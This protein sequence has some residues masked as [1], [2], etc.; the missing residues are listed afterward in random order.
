[1]YP[2][3][4]FHVIGVDKDNDQFTIA[5]KTGFDPDCLKRQ[6]GAFV[7][8]FR[9]FNKTSIMLSTMAAPH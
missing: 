4:F 2:I 5:G 3:H 9:M 7:L 1:M 8:Q 6:N